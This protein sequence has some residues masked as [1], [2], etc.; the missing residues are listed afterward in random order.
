MFRDQ[1]NSSSKV[2][3]LNYKSQVFGSG[4]YHYDSSFHP[5]INLKFIIITLKMLHLDS[6]YNDNKIA[7]ISPV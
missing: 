7:N 2:I 4:Q 1:L 6:S 5:C 3:K